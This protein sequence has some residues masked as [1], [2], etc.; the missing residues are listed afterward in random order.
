MPK[1]LWITSPATGTTSHAR[2]LMRT[3]GVECDLMYV[4]N[5]NSY[6]LLEPT[7]GIT[8]PLNPTTTAMRNLLQRYDAIFVNCIA[9]ANDTSSAQ[10]PILNVW[11][12]NWNAPE[13]PPVFH[14]GQ[15][16]T[17]HRT[18]L[19][20]PSDFPIIRGDTTNDTT[21]ANTMWR[22]EPGIFAII[23]GR[24]NRIG[25]RIRLLRENRSIYTR[26]WNYYFGNECAAYLVSNPLSGDSELLAVPDMPDQARLP[27]PPTN[28]RASFAVRYR[29]H[30]FLPMLH[31]SNSTNDR[32]ANRATF[33]TYAFPIFWVLYAL[34]LANIPA[35]RTIPLV[36][37]LDHPVETHPF[38]RNHVFPGQSGVILRHQQVARHRRLTEWMI[39]FA[40]PRGLQFVYG[41][42]S[43][44]RYE[45]STNHFWAMLYQRPGD[46]PDGIFDPG[47]GAQ[48]REETHRILNLL[49]QNPDVFAF[50]IH[51]HTT[52]T[53]SAGGFNSSGYGEITIRRHDD[54]GYR[55]AAP[56]PVPVRSS[57]RII[58]RKVLPA[59]WSPGATDFI[60]PRGRETLVELDCTT[61]DAV[62]YTGRDGT[63][64]AA[65]VYLERDLAEHALLG[66]PI[67]GRVGYTNHARDAHGGEG[68][69]DAWVEFGFRGFRVVLHSQLTPYHVHINGLPHRLRY[70]GLQFVPSVSVD[71]SIAGQGL[72]HSAATYESTS[73]GL[74]RLESPTAREL[75][76]TNNEWMNNA[77]WRAEKG[78]VAI[79]RLLSAAVDLCLYSVCAYQGTFYLH[80]AGEVVWVEDVEGGLNHSPFVGEAGNQTWSGTFIYLKELLLALDEVVQVLSDYLK[81]GTISELME[82]RETVR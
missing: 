23:S 8:A 60:R 5:S 54:S 3:L 42:R 44:S 13:D 20:L 7:S 50:G 2:G 76:G 27:Q 48:G 72:Y 61:S 45:G 47:Y 15:N 62:S 21:I 52:P 71:G 1:V 66:L 29:N 51:D 31:H 57:D 12:Q 74:W 16:I 30:Y 4:I 33:P 49:Q 69:W 19:N 25:T 70:R 53:D 39:E 64:W 55:Y 38:P 43:G 10:N 6:S 37:E 77:T 24:R 65:C 14:F 40:K 82:L 80:P 78:V 73:L 28:T 11:M 59:N 17:V 35:T 81:W 79:R 18:N 36:M 56:N 34:K 22:W 68:Y 75:S 32:L 58:N 67:D 9:A 46:P 63:Y 26:A 41:S